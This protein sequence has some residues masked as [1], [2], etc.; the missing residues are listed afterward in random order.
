[1]D[2]QTVGRRLDDDGDPVPG[3]GFEVDPGGRL[4]EE[5]S[6]RSGPLLSNPV[7][8]EW[9]ASLVPAEETGG[10]YA[11]GII[12]L[13]DR[14][15]PAHYHVGYEERFE[16]LRGELVVEG[17][18]DDHRVPEGETHAVPPETVHAPRYLGDDLTAARVTLRPAGRTLEVVKTLYGL[19]H[20]GKVNE[21][22]QPKFLQGMVS[23]ADLAD[24]TV[25]TSPPPAIVGPLATVVA[26]VARAVGYRPTYSRYDT[27]EFWERRV[28]QPDL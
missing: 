16:V 6:K 17:E 5:L 15:P 7:T 19:A 12:V 23:A 26:P 1:M 3:T 21:D 27:R 2:A 25:F 9:V 11:S 28:E 22:G 4:A 14:G 13:T 20:E 24:D 8:G 18:S 10:E